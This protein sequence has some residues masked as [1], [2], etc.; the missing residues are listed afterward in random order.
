[1]IILWALPGDRLGQ[2]GLPPGASRTE[3]FWDNRVRKSRKLTSGKGVLEPKEGGRKY[4]GDVLGGGASL[5]C[6]PPRRKDRLGARC[7]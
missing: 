2:E 7:E 5:S 6:W 3:F 4:A 1:M